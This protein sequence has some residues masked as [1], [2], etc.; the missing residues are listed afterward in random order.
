MSS[1]IATPRLYD[2]AADDLVR[3]AEV[4]DCIHLLPH[5]NQRL[6]AN[7][8]IRIQ[9]G[10][11][12]LRDVLDGRYRSVI[13]AVND[14]DNA[15]GIIAQLVNLVTTSQWSVPTVTNYAKMFHQAVT[16]HAAHDREPYILKYDLDSMMILALLRPAGQDHFTLQN[17]AHGFQTVT[18]ML[19]GRPDRRP[20]ASVSFLGASSNRLVGDD[21][22]EPSFETVL[23]IMHEAGYRGDVYPSPQMWGAG[24]TG[25]FASYPFPES[26]ERM[27][28]GSS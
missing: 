9:W 28:G 7:A 1:Q 23:R 17:L 12:M 5:E 22:E 21:G 26:L 13:C 14:T 27:R 19:Q 24:E 15:H 11:D 25:I 18:K 6:E 16:I 4:T 10:H 2:D 3:P 20:V 8:R